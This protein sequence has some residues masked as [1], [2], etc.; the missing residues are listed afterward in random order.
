[1]R[2]LRAIYARHR[3]EWQWRGSIDRLAGTDELRH[4]VE[5]GTV[6]AL[7]AKWAAQAQEFDAASRPY[8]LYP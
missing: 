8:R 6:D 4:A 1:V 5:Q 3:A 7:L 2:L